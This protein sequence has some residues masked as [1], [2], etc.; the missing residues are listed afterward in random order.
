[1]TFGSFG[2]NAE[3][4]PLNSDRVSATDGHPREE[5]LALVLACFD[6]RRRAQQ[7]KFNAE[8]V[9]KAAGKAPL[10]HRASCVRD[11]AMGRT[12]AEFKRHVAFESQTG[13]DCDT[14]R[15]LAEI[16][17][18]AFTQSAV[19]RNAPDHCNIKTGRAF[20]DAIADRGKRKARVG[21]NSLMGV[22]RVRH[23][24]DSQRGESGCGDLALTMVLRT[25]AH[26]RFPR[27]AKRGPG[28]PPRLVSGSTFQ[29]P[30]HPEL[31]Q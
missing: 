23:S 21:A 1:M 10:S 6:A 13:V 9:E 19:G 31:K 5:L 27:S 18:R 26:N 30:C 8:V 17:I 24:D 12:N 25:L 20:D 29:N 22:S 4:K 7:R 28:Q 11:P 14:A 15:Q 16:D 3:R 2:L